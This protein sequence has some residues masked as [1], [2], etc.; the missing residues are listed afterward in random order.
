MR[1]IG[2]LGLH[3]RDYHYNT[4]QVRWHMRIGYLI[5]IL[6]GIAT[7]YV[8][9][10]VGAIW[11]VY[12]ILLGTLI[13]Y[14]LFMIRNIF[15]IY[16]VSKF[17]PAIELFHLGLILRQ[18]RGV[19]PIVLGWEDIQDVYIERDALK[20][21]VNAPQSIHPTITYRIQYLPNREH[22]LSEIQRLRDDSHEK[23]SSASSQAIPH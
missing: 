16:D 14:Y 1:R 15:D 3:I 17:Y 9:R 7:I 23:S 22:V 20:I 12:P 19:E 4:S 5:M 10:Y 11:S 2:E 18:R 21:V 6:C 13:F 8:L